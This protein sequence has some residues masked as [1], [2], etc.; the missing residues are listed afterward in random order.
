VINGTRPTAGQ[1]SQ[2]AIKNSLQHRPSSG[3]ERLETV[4]DGS[5]CELT[6]MDE[7]NSGVIPSDEWDAHRCPVV[8]SVFRGAV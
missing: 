6:C 7:M 5:P 8:R 2:A 4:A 3:I 1:S